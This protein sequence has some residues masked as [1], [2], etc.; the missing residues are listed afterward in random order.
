M[1]NVIAGQP[2]Q[3]HDGM[4]TD[5]TYESV[6]L[7]FCPDDAAGEEGRYEVGMLWKHPDRV[8]LPDAR[9]ANGNSGLE[10]I[11]AVAV[12]LRCFHRNRLSIDDRAFG[13]NFAGIDLDRD[14]LGRKLCK[15]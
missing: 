8:A 10:L 1:V 15:K 12:C 7:R 6:L 4:V 13:V 5:H 3:S 11:P 9:A 2:G 14:V